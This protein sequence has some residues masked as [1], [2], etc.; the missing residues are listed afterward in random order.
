[1]IRP[2]TYV[3]SLGLGGSSDLLGPVLPLLPELPRGLLDLLGKAGSDES[4]SGL[5]LLLGRLVVVD[6]RES[7]RSSSS[8]GGLEAEARDSDRGLGL[9][10]GSELLSELLSRHV[11][12][13]GVDNVNHELK[14][15]V[16]ERSKVSQRF[17]RARELTVSHPGDDWD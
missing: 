13:S 12:S 8:E 3:S 5:E 10:H 1:M 7:G 14:G 9:V 16:E 11:G 15:E 6:E 4:V 2:I 17:G